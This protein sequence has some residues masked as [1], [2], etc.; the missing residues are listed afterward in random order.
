MQE[1]PLISRARAHGPR[2][3]IV[4]DGSAYSYL[5]LLDASAAVAATLLLESPDLAEARVAFQAPAGFTY[6]AIQWGIWR[7]GGVA[8]PLGVAATKAELEHALADSGS[9]QVIAMRAGAE[10]FAALAGY[11]TRRLLVFEDLDLMTAGAL[12]QIA[13]QRRAMILFTSGTTNQPKGVVTTHA[14]IQAQIELLVAA[15]EWHADDCIPLFLP[16]HHIHGII[17]VACCA[18]WAGASIESFPKFAMDTLLE[19]VAAGAYSIFMAVPTIYV[20][21]IEALASDA[22]PAAIRE[23]VLRG[24][25]AMRLM[26]SGSA[27][28]PPSVHE[29]WTALTGQHLL[30]RYGMSETGMTLSN[31]LH[32]ERRPGAVGQ[33]LPTVEL[34]LKSEQGQWITEDGEPGE[35]LV[36]GP[37]VFR[38]YWNSPAITAASFDHGWFRTG[39][40]AV[41]ET[42][43]YR[44]MGR[45]SIDI[46]KSGGYKLSALEI[47]ATLLEHPAIREC[48]VVGLKDDTWGE[49][50]A[51][52]A[53][54]HADTTA[55][56]LDE[57][58]HWS[59]ERLSHYKLP[60]RLLVLNSLPRN[61]M[62]KVTKRVLSDAMCAASAP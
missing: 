50:V 12:P 14:N 51:V 46:I 7:A 38:E 5:D 18:L 56:Q 13:P 40:L 1:L 30:E 35:I 54:L 61:A 34:G 39:D 48:A 21:L 32:G 28:L 4:T 6:L 3:A 44:I 2:T 25:G 58:Q 49:V 16:M 9:S 62:G 36:R 22:Y 10:N 27:A 60:R 42:G 55:L 57:L 19:R 8:V 20:K 11:A 41:M 47:E 29:R 24:F 53:V 33:A 45:L 31:P 43:Y 37:M 23:P 26:V 59:K 17:N 52:A 15:W